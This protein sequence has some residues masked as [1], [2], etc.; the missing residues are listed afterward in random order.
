M[1]RPKT[2]KK[3]KIKYAEKKTLT[4]SA[5]GSNYMYS[6]KKKHLK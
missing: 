4:Q 3:L 5:E 2:N 1:L 6:L